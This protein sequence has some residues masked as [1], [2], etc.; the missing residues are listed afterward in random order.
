MAMLDLGTL[1]ID[2]LV[3]S[4][5]A[6]QK[7]DELKNKSKSTA[8]SVGTD[9]NKVAD[10]MVKTGTALT[11]YITLPVLAAAT[12]SVKY[13]SD[14]TE[15]TNKVSVVFGKNA[16]AIGRWS[17]SSLKYMGLAKE[18]AMDMAA[19]FGDL[20][21]S[22]GIVDD[23]NYE[24]STSL[25]QLAAD[26]ASFKNISAE[27]A[28]E[29]LAGIYTGETEALK[30]LGIVM[31]D[32]NLEAFAL[33][34][35]TGKQ[36]SEM[37]QAEKVALRYQYVI[38]ASSNAMGDFARTS[39]G[40]ANQT[41]M[42][43]ESLKETA[44]EFGE[45]LAPAA[46]DV[47][48]MLNELLDK[49][50]SMNPEAQ[51]TVVTIA[52]IA[53]G[54]GPLLVL[55]GKGIKAYND[56]AKAVAAANVKMQASAGVIGLVSLA[57]GL[58]TAAVI[59]GIA[60]Y[61]ELTKAAED[62]STANK[63]AS[64]SIKTSK[65]TL[66]STLVSISA[67]A[68]MAQS[69]CDRLDELTAAETLTNAQRAEAKYLVDQLNAT[70]PDLNASIDENTGKIIGG[71]TA[72]R[73][74]ITAMQ[75]QA[76]AQAYLD[77]YNA[78]L[79]AHA[80]L[81][82]AAAAAETEKGMIEESNNAIAE[83]MIS[84]AEQFQAAT[85]SSISAMAELDAVQQTALLSGND[86]ALTMLGTY[87]RLDG[88]LNDNKISMRALDRELTNNATATAAAKN[89]VDIATKTYEGL[90]GASKDL[91]NAS[92]ETGDALAGT[93]DAA[94]EASVKVK[95]YTD[96]TINNL[97][98]LAPAVKMS[99]AEATA[100]LVANNA[101][102]TT[103]MNNLSALVDKGMDEGVVA[104]LYELG[105]NFRSVVADLVDSTPEEMQAFEDALGASGDFSGMKFKT[106][107]EN[108]TADVTETLSSKKSEVD[109]WTRETTSTVAAAVDNGIIAKLNSIVPAY[110]K[111]IAALIA[112]NASQMAQFATGM[113]DGGTLAAVNFYEGAKIA[114]ESRY[115][116]FYLLGYKAGLKYKQGYNDGTE[117]ASPSRAAIRAVGYWVEGIEVATKAGLG[118]IR[119]AALEAAAVQV[120]TA[121]SAFQKTPKI[122]SG[123]LPS[124]PAVTHVSTSTSTTTRSIGK[125]EQNNTY[126]TKPFSPYELYQQQ[127]INSKTLAEA[128]S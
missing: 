87:M 117:V 16:D 7:F 115:Q 33:T 104:K 98:R 73:D 80:D 40:T 15:T 26:M 9:W 69:Y 24:M 85:G 47:V 52:L 1:K 106:G 127:R 19:S 109:T 75:E 56:I 94:A 3:T 91:T 123:A 63:K 111:V 38:Q 17:D 31:T 27:R 55:I 95:D 81:L 39:D 101:E 25:V 76:A 84:L 41:R 90:T 126:L 83:E 125:V 128:I 105:P 28:Q 96:E 30:G 34:Q 49:I 100:N 8:E 62:L 50:K 110:S 103:W 79:T 57:L 112:V 82:Y 121:K 13:A 48:H 113:R 5:E 67:S 122:L 102:M 46:N 29:A 92:S 10:D 108:G 51:K 89:E 6:N 107:V 58:V 74:Q 97:E 20:G 124:T 60:N 42:L 119:R 116:Q 37:T 12:A 68:Q 21:S 23:K 70:Y 99:A 66:D 114:T 2:V 71:T 118:K 54:V 77:Q 44:T 93:G 43:K 59:A 65:T 53:A 120:D 11:K 4:G 86:A 36:Y 61:K 14:M 22:M 18:T 35:N 45:V 32:A 78:V 88:E 64:D 72:I